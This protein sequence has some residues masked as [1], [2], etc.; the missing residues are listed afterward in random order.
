[1]IYLV[2]PQQRVLSDH[3]RNIT[4]DQ[5][6]DKLSRA[7]YLQVD[8]ETTGLSFLDDQ[9]LLIQIGTSEVQVVYDVRNGIDPTVKTLLE[10]SSKLKMLHN[11]VFDYKF[12][13]KAGIVLNH[14]WDTMIIEKLLHNGETTP[15]GFYKLNNVVERYT[16]TE[17]SKE[18]Q[19]SFINHTG[20]DFTNSQLQYAAS[21]VMYLEQVREGQVAHLKQSKLMQCAK[22][23]NEA[24]LGFG[25]IEYN[26]M[27]VDKDLWSALGKAEG[28][29][30]EMLE[31]SLN[32]T[33]LR[34]PLFAE[35]APET[36]QTTLF[37]TDEQD[38]AASVTINWSSPTQVLPILQ[39][40]VPDLENCD[41]K[42][43]A[44]AHRQDHE[45]IDFYI[46]YRESSKLSTAFGQEWLDKYVCSDGK[47]HTR[48]QQILRTGRVSSS[49]PN[50]QQ[51][52][53]N[54]AYRN[55]FICPKGWSYI[56]SDFSSQELCIIAHGSQDPVWLKSLEKGEDLHSVCADLVY[57]DVWHSAAGP[58]CEY[59][60]SK[61]KC[62]CSEHKK[63]RTAVKSI[64]FGLAYGMGP[65]KLASQLQI[66]LDEASELIKTYFKVFPSIKEYLDGNAGFG[67]KHGY[68]RTMEPYRRIRYFPDWRGRATDKALMGKIDRM[69]RNTPIQGTA[70]DMT[71]EAMV[72]CRREFQNKS[73]IQMVMVVH[74]QLDFIVKT[75]TLEYYSK[76]ITKHMEAAGKSIITNGLLKA[77]T[78]TSKSWE[79]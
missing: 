18:M 13:K 5:A 25:D 57:G 48:F 1:M 35:F 23:E 43:L 50:M 58:E 39:A 46:S 10:D 65:N 44:L 20:A 36:Y 34:D 33:I 27:L 4:A 9:L 8:C 7:T 52:P 16:Q 14:I 66:S 63:L 51:I 53:A 2:S 30:A 3:I 69:S 17:L 6:F 29:K 49:G 75:P 59:L 15:H 28:L 26:G 42:N 72:R 79:K 73:D 61:S 64:N 11:A 38:L 62:S 31:V 40:I 71:K 74:D 76:R 70:G 56:S 78:T 21:D 67:K 77:D 47:V 45:L 19:S 68:I 22:L 60:R 55:C 37:G 12:L 54:N 41:T 24:C 32:E